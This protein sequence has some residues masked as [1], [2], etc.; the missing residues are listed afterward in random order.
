MENFVERAAALLA[1]ALEYVSPLVAFAVCAGLAVFAALLQV[2]AARA[3]TSVI[4]D[5][6]RVKRFVVRRGEI[7]SSNAHRF[8]QQMRQAHGAQDTPRVEEARALRQRVRGQR[9][10][11]SRWIAVSAKSAD[12]AGYI[13]RLHLRRSRCCRRCCCARGWRGRSLRHTLR[14]PRRYGQSQR[15]PT[16]AYCAYR[17]RRAAGRAARLSEMLAAKLTL[18]P[19]E[20][21]L[22]FAPSE[23][24]IAPVAAP[25]PERTLRTRSENMSPAKPDKEVA[26]RC[27]ARWKR[28]AITAARMPSRRRR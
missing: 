25:C 4:G 7:V 24:M 28:Q 22:I 15:L 17:A 16:A 3:A 20:G 6:R 2:F 26:R 9:A 19:A 14:A 21:R 27:S 18:R 23:A 11:N 5:S 10:S 12:R 13:C 8:L 1:R